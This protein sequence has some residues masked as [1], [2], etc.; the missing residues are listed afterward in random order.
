MAKPQL[1]P[2]AM[3]VAKQLIVE[4]ILAGR[5]LPAV[6]AGMSPGVTWH[7]LQKWRRDDPDFHEAINAAIEQ[8]GRVPYYSDSDIAEI[9]AYLVHAVAEQRKTLSEAVHAAGLGWRT[10]GK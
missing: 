6:V 10:L 8:R 7:H 3:A 5:S 9:K 1:P 4:L 2:E